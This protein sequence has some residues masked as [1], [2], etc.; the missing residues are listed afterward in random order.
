MPSYPDGVLYPTPVHPQPQSN[1]VSLEFGSLAN[2]QYRPAARQQSARQTA[3][4]ILNAPDV[5]LAIVVGSI[6]QQH[7]ARSLAETKAK[8]EQQAS[9]EKAVEYVRHL[10]REAARERLNATPVK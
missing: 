3:A 5:Q 10:E 7:N 2:I 4:R 1:F 9:F 6:I 8:L